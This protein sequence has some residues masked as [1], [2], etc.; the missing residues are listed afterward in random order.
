MAISRAEILKRVQR[1]VNADLAELSLAIND[2]HEESIYGW[3]NEFTTTVIDLIKD[4]IH[5][6]SLNV[7]GEALTFTTG[8][9]DLPN[10]FQLPRT[11][12]VSASYY[13][14]SGDEVSVTSRK[15]Q[16]YTDPNDFDRFDSSSFVLTPSGKR[17]VVLITDKIYVKPTTITSGTIDY[18]KSHPTIDGSSGSLFDDKGDTALILFILEAY[19]D[20]IE[21]MEAKA[22]IQKEIEAMKYVD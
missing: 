3:A 20:F 4:P 21:A 16:I 5:F 15:A 7:T 11:V 19:Y 17:P 14:L 9:E 18:I 22:M 1:R 2:V 10:N 6:P 13:D 12:K 8:V